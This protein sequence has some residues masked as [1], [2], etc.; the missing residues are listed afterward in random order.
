MAI[1]KKGTGRL[2]EAE[3]RSM[4]ETEANKAEHEKEQAA[5]RTF[6]QRGEHGQHVP[7]RINYCLRPNTWLHVLR[8]TVIFP[9]TPRRPTNHDSLMVLLLPD[10]LGGSMLLS[11]CKTRIFLFPRFTSLGGLES[12]RSNFWGL[13][14]FCCC[15]DTALKGKSMMGSDA[16]RSSGR[17]SG[18]RGFVPSSSPRSKPAPLNPASLPP[19]PSA[20]SDLRKLGSA[21]FVFAF[22]AVFD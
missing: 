7:P 11:I 16:S 4:T 21:F 18:N 15:R 19:S 20:D 12:V 3:I 6:A 2:R 14:L 1:V 8:G 13:L 9:L 5:V 22:F 10:A 17:R